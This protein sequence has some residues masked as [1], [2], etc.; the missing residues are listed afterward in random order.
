MRARRA[1][2][3]Y[4][5]RVATRCDIC[6]DDDCQKV[7]TGKLGSQSTGDDKGAASAPARPEALLVLSVILAVP[8]AYLRF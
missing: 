8:L 5:P 6:E 2:V 4:E 7:C 1:R 3:F